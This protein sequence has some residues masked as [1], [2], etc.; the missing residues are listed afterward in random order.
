[1]K[2][3]KVENDKIIINF[4]FLKT[5]SK[6]FIFVLLLISITL[7]IY[8]AFHNKSEKENYCE[9]NKL[10]IKNGDYYYR[11][12]EEKLRIIPSDAKIINE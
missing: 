7:N 1:M 12:C 4:K 3:I 6:I 11:V 2:N 8:F 5:I 9:T 10:Y